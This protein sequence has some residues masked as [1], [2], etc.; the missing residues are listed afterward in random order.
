MNLSI[1]YIKK[2]NMDVVLN[3][4][5]FYTQNIFVHIS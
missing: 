1:S 5:Y 4:P 3:N 2:D